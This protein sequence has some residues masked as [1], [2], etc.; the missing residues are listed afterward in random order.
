MAIERGRQYQALSV[1]LGHLARGV[2]DRRC[3]SR[4]ARPQR[5]AGD[6]RCHA[7]AAAG[8]GRFAAVAPSPCSS[9]IISAIRCRLSSADGSPS[10]MRKAAIC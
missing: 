3:L 6:C 5:G 1:D 7:G 4:L 10:R 8:R 2:S 9:S